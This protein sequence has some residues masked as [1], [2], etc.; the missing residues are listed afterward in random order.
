MEPFPVSP[1]PQH[2]SP[3][4]RQ[5]SVQWNLYARRNMAHSDCSVTM[6]TVPNPSRLPPLEMQP[7]PLGSTVNQPGCAAGAGYTREEGRQ[8]TVEQLMQNVPGRN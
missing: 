7:G 2:L 8:F 1:S 6:T 5:P 3:T 4:T